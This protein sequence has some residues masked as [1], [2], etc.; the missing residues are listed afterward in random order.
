LAFHKALVTRGY[1][2]TFYVYLTAYGDSA[3]E[4]TTANIFHWTQTLTTSLLHFQYFFFLPRTK[5]T[6]KITRQELDTARLE[7]AIFRITT[8]PVSLLD[9][10]PES[11]KNLLGG[12]IAGAHPT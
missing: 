9:A 11:L 4:A 10:L 6:S 12:S 2:I 7:L 1:L 3:N 5:L 8:R